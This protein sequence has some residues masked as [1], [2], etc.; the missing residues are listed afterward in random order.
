MK[1]SSKSIICIW[2][3]KESTWMVRHL[4]FSDKSQQ[5]AKH[6]TL[7]AIQL[8][9]CS[10]FDIHWR[11]AQAFHVKINNSKHQSITS[12]TQNKLKDKIGGTKETTFLN[13]HTLKLS[14]HESREIQQNDDCEY[15][16]ILSF[17]VISW[18]PASN[19]HALLAPSNNLRNFRS[20]FLVL[21]FSFL[22]RVFS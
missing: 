11:C 17:S 10:T 4:F 12:H 6:V 16:K 3:A 21:F 9:C 20:S 8:I 7:T 2:I 14:Q 19:W 15:T 1:I 5:K 22:W 18:F 13:T